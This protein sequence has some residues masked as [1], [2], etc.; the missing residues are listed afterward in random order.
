[1]GDIQR[2]AGFGDLPFKVKMWI[3]FHEL[4]RSYVRYR[5]QVKSVKYLVSNQFV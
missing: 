3:T 1:M 4:N 2:T 5:M